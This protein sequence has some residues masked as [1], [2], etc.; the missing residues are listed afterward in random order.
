M[1][2]VNS[3]TKVVRAITSEFSIIEKGE[4]QFTVEAG[5]IVEILGSKVDDSFLS[6]VSIKVRTEDGVTTT[7]DSNFLSCR[8]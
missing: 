2:T 8:R 3:K 5:S 4:I 1:S 6:G 7:I